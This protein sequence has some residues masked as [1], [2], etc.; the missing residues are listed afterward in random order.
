MLGWPTKQLRYRRTTNC[1]LA[2]TR[3]SLQKLV[4]YGI[5]SEPKAKTIKEIVNKVKFE[6]ISR[7]NLSM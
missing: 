2:N 7:N 4:K 6:S 5:K 3:Y 1:I